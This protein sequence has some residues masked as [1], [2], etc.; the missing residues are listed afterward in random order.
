MTFSMCPL[1][2]PLLLWHSYHFL[3]S[4]L[5]VIIEAGGPDG[6]AHRNQHNTV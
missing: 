3:S 2:Q 4:N 6:L 5:E 1:G